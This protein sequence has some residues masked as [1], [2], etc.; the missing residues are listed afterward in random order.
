MTRAIRRIGLVLAILLVALLANVTFIQVFRSDDL[1][2][3]ADNQRV[4]LDEYGR[5]RGPI[6][7]MPQGRVLP[8]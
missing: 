6:L 8:R 5:Q 4:I 2:A 1:R 3:R 7:C